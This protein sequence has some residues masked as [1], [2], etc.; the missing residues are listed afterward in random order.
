M[1]FWGDPTFVLL[2][3]AIL[4]SLY[5]QFKVQATFEQYSRIPSRRGLTGAQ[6][7]REILDRAGLHDVRVEM[8]Q[9]FLSDHYDPRSKVLRLSPAVYQSSSL[10]SLGV[11]AHEAGHALQHGTGYIPLHIRSSLVPLVSFGSNL[12]IPLL[13]LGLIMGIPSLAR[14]GI[15]AFL[16]VVIFSLVTLPVEFNA[17]RRAV[18]LLEGGGYLTVQEL[19]GAKEVLNAA[20]LTYVAAALAAILNLLRLIMLMG[21]FGRREE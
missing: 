3:P 19:R 14:L 16:L 5:A 4:L 6:V 2:I 17:S 21:F 8:I 13:I 1:F 20:A 18:A 9:G 12:A 15:Y 11:A 10:A 7:A